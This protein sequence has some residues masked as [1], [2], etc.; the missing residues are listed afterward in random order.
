MKMVAITPA[1]SLIATGSPSARREF[2]DD[3]ASQINPYWANSISDYRV[4]VTER[5]AWLKNEFGGRNMFEMLTES[6]IKLGIEVRKIREQVWQELKI[7][8][9]EEKIAFNL[10]S[11]GNLTVA[12]FAKVYP[13]EK[14][15]EQTLIG[16]NKDDWSLS[17]SGHQVDRFASTG[18]A[19]KVT[20]ALKLAQ[21]RLITRLTGVEPIILA[22]DLFAELDKSRACQALTQMESFGQAFITC[23]QKPPAGNYFLIESN[24]WASHRN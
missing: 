5:N 23:A 16:P 10:A 15:R 24:T 12:D 7:S 3:T 20:L 6:V 17:L 1:T 13:K 14:A 21:A 2:L 11:S 9:E 22:D 19:R 8:L 4:T 18:E